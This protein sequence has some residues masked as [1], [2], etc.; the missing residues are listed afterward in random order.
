M[1]TMYIIYGIGGLLALVSIVVAI[2]NWFYLAST[3]SKIIVIE[4]EIQKK[5]TEFDSIKKEIKQQGGVTRS[6]STMPAGNDLGASGEIP[7]P[8][9]IDEPQ[10][11]VVRNVRAEF[12]ETDASDTQA[13][14]AQQDGQFQSVNSELPHL[15]AE[16][17]PAPAMHSQPYAAANADEQSEYANQ[18]PPEAA[19]S[20]QIERH[21]S[22]TP[23]A[24]PPAEQENGS[25]PSEPMQQTDQV[26]AQ[27]ASG[28]TESRTPQSMPEMEIEQPPAEAED[29]GSI[30]ITRIA[31]IPVAQSPEFGQ[32]EPPAG[33]KES[34]RSSLDADVLDVVDDADNAARE[35]P[36]GP[37]TLE[38]QL[39]SDTKKDADFVGAWKILSEKLPGIESPVVR[40]DCSN[41]LFLYPKEMQYLERILASVHSYHGSLELH[42]CQ[43]ELVS[44]L[45]GNPQLAACI[46]T[47]G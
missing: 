4:S 29:T 39:F 41:I 46:R 2:A 24:H 14:E 9:E 5:T 25:S 16:E 10:I 6:Q 11:E 12:R 3:S 27:H 45:N 15:P 20:P 8:G 19:A 23:A 40:F 1:E 36:S 21:A 7:Q 13:G 35:L 38:I 44:I 30:E 37:G 22:D 33:H 17:E 18:Q 43:R 26:S 34:S 42:H 32:V 28:R 47:R 31:E